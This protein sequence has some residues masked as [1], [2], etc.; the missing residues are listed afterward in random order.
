MG[1]LWMARGPSSG[2]PSD[3]QF[4]YLD[5]G[6]GSFLIQALVALGAGVAGALRTYWEKVRSFL[7]LARRDSSQA[8]ADPTE[9]DD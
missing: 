2:P 9:R 5:P 6:S 3:F 4:A 7:G 1:A 8:E